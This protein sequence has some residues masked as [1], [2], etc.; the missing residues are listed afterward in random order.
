MDEKIVRS[1]I[2]VLGNKVYELQLGFT[3]MFNLC[4][5]KQVFT[6]EAFHQERAKLEAHPDFQ[7]LRKILDHVGNPTEDEDFESLLKGYKG[8]VH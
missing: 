3:V 8:P 1:L 4:V 2:E 7:K 6:K 5:N